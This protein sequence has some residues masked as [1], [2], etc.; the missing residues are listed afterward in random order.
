MLSLIF[1]LVVGTGITFLSMQNTEVVTLN[2]LDYTFTNLPIYY[3]IIGSILTGVVLA[4]SISFINSIST[5]MLIRTQH[6]KIGKERKEV[7]ELTKR[8]HQLE[9]ENVGLKT[10]ND[11]TSFDKK[12]L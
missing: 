7:A 3:V 1:L 11:P 6:K 12:S 2:F 8:V 5:Y 4:Y 9:I 10:E